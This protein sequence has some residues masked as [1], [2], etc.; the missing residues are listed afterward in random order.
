[1]I[2]NIKYNEIEDEF[3]ND[4]TL[5]MRLSKYINKHFYHQYNI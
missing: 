2:I 4:L 1:M 5:E 3:T